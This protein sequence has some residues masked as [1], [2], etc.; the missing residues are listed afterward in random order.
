MGNYEV[1]KSEW[2]MV[3]IWAL[4]NGY[5]DLAEGEGK[6]P[7]HPVQSVSWYGEV[8]Q[9]AQPDGGLDAVLHRGGCGLSD[10]RGWRSRL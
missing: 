4:Q 7:D 5:T 3:R 10:G 2:D 9:C 1:T 8:V 6:A